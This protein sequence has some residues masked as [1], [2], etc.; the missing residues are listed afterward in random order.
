MSNSRIFYG[1]STNRIASG[2]LLVFS[3]SSLLFYLIPY[4]EAIKFDDAS[5]VIPLFPLTCFYLYSFRSIF[6]EALIA[7]RCLVL[8]LVVRLGF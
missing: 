8:V 6:K 7:N 2:A 4:F 1:V 3:G 5:R